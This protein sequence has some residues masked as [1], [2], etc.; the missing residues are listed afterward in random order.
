MTIDTVFENNQLRDNGDDDG[1]NVGMIKGSK[2]LRGLDTEE[3]FSTLQ[4]DLDR[5]RGQ[6]WRLG[7]TLSSR[8]KSV[9][10]PAPTVWRR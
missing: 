1:R 7:K 3:E 6:W 9:A 2:F 4:W 10:H 5:V 8:K